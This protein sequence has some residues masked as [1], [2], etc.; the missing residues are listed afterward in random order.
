[1]FFIVFPL[2]F[3]SFLRFNR[4]IRAL[5]LSLIIKKI[6]RILVSIWISYQSFDELV[7]FKLSFELN[8][9]VQ[10]QGSFTLFFIRLPFT[11]IQSFRILI[12]SLSIFFI[13]C[14]ISIIEMV[15]SI[16]KLSLT[17]FFSIL[18]ISFINRRLRSIT[19][20]D[21]SPAMK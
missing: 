5:T 3:I 19:F 10:F 4:K 21:S 12:D 17:M 11:I 1:M 14:P 20:F 6:S 18:K 2:T 13:K 8:S 7:I 9:F 15:G 16:L